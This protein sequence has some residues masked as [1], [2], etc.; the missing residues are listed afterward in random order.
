PPRPP[1]R[2]ARSYFGSQWMSL[3]PSLVYF[4]GRSM[5]DE[6]S[7][8]RRLKAFYE[9][10]RKVVTDETFFPTVIMNTPAFA[11]TVPGAGRGEGFSAG[12]PWLKS[13][14]FERMDEHAP[15]CAG[16]LPDKQRVVAMEGV[17]PRVWGPYFLGVYDLADIIESGAL[18][19]RKVSSVVEGNLY[20]VFPKDSREEVEALPR[21]AWDG[22][23]EYEISE[24]PVF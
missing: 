14:R 15:S 21:I 20:K 17:E 5:R 3:S 16:A 6:H 11:P 19:F 18:W 8:A 13:A 1:P 2:P 24:R 7:L 22:D 9:L 10:K 12:L 23:V 4:L